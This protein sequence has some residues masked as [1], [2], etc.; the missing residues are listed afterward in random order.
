MSQKLIWP[1]QLDDAMKLN[2]DLARRGLADIIYDQAVLEGIATTRAD[3]VAIV[4][5]QKVHDMLP[6]DVVKTHNLKQAWDFV[7]RESVI[8]VPTSLDLIC[9]INKIVQAGLSY[10]AGILR[11]VPVKISGTSWQP[12]LPY[13]S[14]VR[15]ELAHILAG[16][17]SEQVAWQLLLY[18][19]KKQI[20]LD[21]NKRTAVLVANHYLVA[22]GLGMVAIPA[23]KVPVFEKLLIGFYE[24]DKETD[25]LEFLTSRCWQKLPQASIY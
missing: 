4:R 16:P 12:A 7:L 10:H 25:L 20:F 3:T 1:T 24:S 19:M 18:V 9:D 13:E 22:H 8:L 6:D 15:E 2:I 14:V 11:S 21:G 17:A 5:G 23:D